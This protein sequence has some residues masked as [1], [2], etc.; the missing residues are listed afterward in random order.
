MD[1]LRYPLLLIPLVYIYF[2]TNRFYRFQMGHS[3]GYGEFLNRRP[4]KMEM[5]I[6]H[7]T[8]EAERT[9]MVP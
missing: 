9:T 4:I 5:I 6:T 3:P 7:H 8:I 2:L 1:T